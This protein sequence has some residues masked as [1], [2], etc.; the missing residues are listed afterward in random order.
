MNIENTLYVTNRQQWRFWLRRNHKKEKSIWLVF[1]NKSSGKKRIPYNDPVEEALCFGWIDSTVKKIDKDSFAQRFSQRN[2]RSGVSEMNKERIRR[3]IKKKLMTK[4]GISA[5]KHAFDASSEDKLKLAPD[6]LKEIK[7]DKA[8]WKNF[9]KLPEGY[10][11]VRIGYIEARRRHGKKAF[12]NSL[13][14]F[15]KNTARNRKFGM[16]Q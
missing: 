8:A 14:Y 3:L 15:I 5:V 2:P 1:Y 16:V 6:I 7:A 13:R 9:M 12:Q 4:S 11:K 10:K